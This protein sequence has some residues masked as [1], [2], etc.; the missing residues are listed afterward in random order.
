MV[1][2][3]ETVT[4]LI[5]DGKYVVVSHEDGKHNPWE[6]VVDMNEQMGPTWLP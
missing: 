6:V 1:S 3:M 5:K 2:N 4:V